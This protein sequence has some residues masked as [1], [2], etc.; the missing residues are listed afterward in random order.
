M[1]ECRWLGHDS[2]HVCRSLCWR[3]EGGFCFVFYRRR[4]IVSCKVSLYKWEETA[5]FLQLSCS[6]MPNNWL[7]YFFA[8]KCAFT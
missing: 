3:R 1:V 7:L 8:E 6:G 4:Q 5:D 2:R